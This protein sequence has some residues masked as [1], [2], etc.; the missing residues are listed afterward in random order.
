LQGG[1]QLVIK[2]YDV[3]LLPKGMR[4]KMQDEA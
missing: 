4:D 2:G 3:N 1:V